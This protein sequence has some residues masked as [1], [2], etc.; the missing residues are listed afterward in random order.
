M[1]VFV[2]YSLWKPLFC[3]F[4]WVYWYLFRLSG[5]LFVLFVFAYK[6]MCLLLI[7]CCLRLAFCGV[8]CNGFVSWVSGC[9]YL[10]LLLIV[11]VCV[12]LLRF[13]FVGY[14]V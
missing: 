14:V 2:M 1:F 13:D 12:C 6:F 4:G 8:C 7:V 5:V 3:W 10:Q 11:W 9:C